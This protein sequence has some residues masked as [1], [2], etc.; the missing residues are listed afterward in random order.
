MSR[1]GLGPNRWASLTAMG[2]ADL[3]VGQT[4]RFGVRF[5]TGG[6]PWLA[7]LADSTCQL[8]VEIGNRN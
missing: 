4:V 1:V 5:G 3:A 2:T 8:R 6:A 7:D